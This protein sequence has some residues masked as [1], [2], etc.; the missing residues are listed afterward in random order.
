MLGR[1]FCSD[2][3]TRQD[4]FVAERCQ[5]LEA[6]LNKEYPSFRLGSRVDAKP[7]E[8][9][10]GSSSDLPGHATGDPEST[11]TEQGV[12][13]TFSSRRLLIWKAYALVHPRMQDRDASAW[14]GLLP[15]EQL[16]SKVIQLSKDVAHLKSQVRR[17]ANPLAVSWIHDPLENKTRSC[18]AYACF[19][20]NEWWLFRYFVWTHGRTGLPYNGFVTCALAPLSS[21][22]PGSLSGP[23]VLRLDVH[24]FPSVLAFWLGA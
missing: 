10:D 5:L 4:A 3:A 23:P 13:E 14:L 19:A 18:N 17:R 1:D 21:F 8:P 6:F 20:T 22:S 24:A 7:S 16:L 2:F 12:R 11:D 9:V 15:K